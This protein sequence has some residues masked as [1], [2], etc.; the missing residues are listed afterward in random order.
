L[1]IQNSKN[2]IQK[3]KSHSRKVNSEYK[4]YILKRKIRNT[5]SGNA[6]WKRIS[7]FQNCVLEIQIQKCIPKK[8]LEVFYYPHLFFI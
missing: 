5:K 1:K 4:K 8:V 6:F 7:R 3:L 2:T